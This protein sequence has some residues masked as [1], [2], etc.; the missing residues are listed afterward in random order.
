MKCKQVSRIFDIQL[1]FELILFSVK[2]AATQCVFIYLTRFA[3]HPRFR[4]LPLNLLLPGSADNS[5]H[6]SLS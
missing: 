4:D 1:S 5:E 3:P 2:S 6:F